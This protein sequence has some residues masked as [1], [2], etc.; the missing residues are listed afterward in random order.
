MQLAGTL[1]EDPRELSSKYGSFVKLVVITTEKWPN[2]E[3]IWQELKSY[4]HV[5]V[6]DPGTCDYLLR[7]RHKGDIVH[8]DRATIDYQ[9]WRD[10]DDVL[11]KGTAIVVPHTVLPITT[12]FGV[13]RRMYKEQRRQKAVRLVKDNADE[14][15]QWDDESA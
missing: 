6:Y 12:V 13:D 8:I 1:A 9:R 14:Q 5:T 7:Y 4:H 2:V 10:K 15:L 11:H 3:G